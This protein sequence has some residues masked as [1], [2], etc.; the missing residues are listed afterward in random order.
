M[1]QRSV[2]LV[3][4]SLVVLAF[5]AVGSTVAFAGEISTPFQGKDVK[6]G[7]VTHE[8]KAGRH[9]LTLSPDFEVP[10]TPDPHW[11]VVDSRGQ[12]YL[13]DRLKLHEDKINTSITVPAY[14][15]DIAKVQIWC[16]WAEL[17]LGEAS[18]RKPIVASRG[19]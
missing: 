9:V 4:L 12:V 10:G 16:A 15:R 13:L 18:F 5:V 3:V 17:L 2:L 6:H 8:V 1:K 14:V 7:T 11:Q 19:R